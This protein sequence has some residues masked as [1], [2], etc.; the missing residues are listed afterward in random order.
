MAKPLTV[1]S[2]SV[3]V[4][5]EEMAQRVIETREKHGQLL[6]DYHKVWYESGHTWVYT[7]FAGIGLMKSPTDLWAYQDLMWLHRPKTVIETGTYQGGSALWLAFLMDILR[8][9]DGMILT[10]DLEDQRQCSHPRIQFI[11]GDSTDPDL[12]YDLISLVK[13]P[14]LV[15]LDADHAAAH[16][17]KELE[18]YAPACQ[19]G[20][21]L[22]VEDTNISW[23]D[24]NLHD[25]LLWDTA[26]P[27]G[28]F[29]AKCSC[30]EIWL[31]PSR[32]HVRCPNDKG[33][34]GARGGVEDYLMAHEGEFRQDVLSER[35]LMSCNPGG[36]L[37]RVA[38]CEHG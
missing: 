17:R 15:I 21:W 16:V 36:F 29:T 34:R 30:G 37:Q 6:Q 26:E 18:L 38:E 2:P 24:D 28:Q 12:A 1:V 27:D 22:V 32:R 33:D 14:L 3:A 9:D 11:Q 23:N 5:Q 10:V 19:L 35:W 8:I 13:Y 4:T 25:V 7:Q 20:D 31:T